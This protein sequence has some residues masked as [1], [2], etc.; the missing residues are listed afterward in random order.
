LLEKSF[1]CPKTMGRR[2]NINNLRVDTSFLPVE[3]NGHKRTYRICL[4]R[5]SK[6]GEQCLHETPSQSNWCT[7][8]SYLMSKIRHWSTNASH[9]SSMSSLIMEIGSPE[10]QE[11]MSN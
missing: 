7:C 3:V 11:K 8:L 9:P 2:D 1:W 5:T 6:K 4:K 10:I